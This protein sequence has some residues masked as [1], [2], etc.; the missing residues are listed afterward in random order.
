LLV[1][2]VE[3]A[4]DGSLPGGCGTDG[5]DTVAGFGELAAQPSQAAGDFPV[6]AGFPFVEDGEAFGV[7][8]D[9]QQQG[10]DRVCRAAVWRVHRVVIARGRG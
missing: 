10:G 7:L 9:L 5:V 1:E 3:R 4:K 2:A 6:V 8:G